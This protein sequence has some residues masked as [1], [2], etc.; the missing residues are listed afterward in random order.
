ML[1]SVIVPC[2]N[3]EAVL[4]STHKRLTDVLR[5]MNHLRFEIIYVDDGSRDQTQNVLAELQAQSSEVR[6]LRL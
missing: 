4:R 2:F 1:L 3:E 6:V 5:E